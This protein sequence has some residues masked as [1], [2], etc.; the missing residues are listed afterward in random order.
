MNKAEIESTINGDGAYSVVEQGNWVINLDTHTY[1]NHIVQSSEDL[2]FYCL[3]GY[4][5]KAP[6]W[7]YNSSGAHLIE[8]VP[9]EKT[10]VHWREVGEV[11]L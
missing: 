8:V 1:E 4:I 6:H 11:C 5:R 7:L 10:V 9:V 3:E 2:K